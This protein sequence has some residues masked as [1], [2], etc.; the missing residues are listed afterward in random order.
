MVDVPAKLAARAR[1]LGSGSARKTDVTDAVSVASVAIHN[2]KLSVV[3][4]EGP[5]RRA[6][7][8][9]RSPRRRCL[10]THTHHEPPPGPASQPRARGRSS[11]AVDNRGGCVP[12]PSPPRHPRRSAAQVDR[13][14]SPRRS[15]PCRSPACDHGQDHRHRGRRQRHRTRGDPRGRIDPR[16]QDHRPRRAR[17]PLRVQEPLRQLHRDSARRGPPAATHAAIDSTEQGTAS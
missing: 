4:A 1:L 7:P 15:S 17:H 9:L 5:H 8:A 12:G 3:A 2:P 6:A 13:P 14:R 16:G 10:P 11:A